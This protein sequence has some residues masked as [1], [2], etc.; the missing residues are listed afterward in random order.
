MGRF[1]AETA[2]P[3]GPGVI[4]PGSP[5]GR[6][7]GRAGRPWPAREQ[8]REASSGVRPGASAPDVLGRASRGF[9]Q[10]WPRGA[11]RRTVE[12]CGGGGGRSPGWCCRSPAEAAA[13]R[14]RSCVRRARSRCAVRGRAGCG[15][16][17]SPPGCRWCM[18]RRR[19]PMPYG[20][21]CSPTRSAG[22]SGWPGPWAERSPRPWRPLR[23]RRRAPGDVRCSL[24]RCR[25]PG[26]PYGRVGTIRR[27]G[28]RSRRR[29]GCGG[30]GGRRGSCPCC[31]NGGTWRTRRGWGR[32]GGSRTWPG[33]WRS[34]RAASGS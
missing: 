4:R 33:H 12:P 6:S 30:R 17:P 3:P 23:G 14:G 20:N 34:R 32:V 10:G 16:R 9:P 13:G 21:C 24:Y 29:P 22:R 1:P 26:V 15:P 31:A 25:R 11:G 18:P 28:S 7:R 19:T 2:A 8:G 5:V 27:A